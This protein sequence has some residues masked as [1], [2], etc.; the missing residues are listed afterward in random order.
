MKNYINTSRK[1]TDKFTVA[2]RDVNN[3]RTLLP[4]VL[5]DKMNIFAMNSIYSFQGLIT[6]EP[7]LYKLNILKNAFLNDKL[8]IKSRI[9]KLSENELQLS[10]E[11][12]KKLDDS[13]DTICNALYRVILKENKLE[14][15]S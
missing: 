7:T 14:R 11:V 9:K 3:S 1:T 4:I 6:A 15:A 2:I 10:I 12:Y 13:N 8:H 5:Y